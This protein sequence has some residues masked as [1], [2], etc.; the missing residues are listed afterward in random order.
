MTS[1][2]DFEKE[3][4]LEKL[5]AM[6]FSLDLCNLCLR[7]FDNDLKN[8]IQFLSENKNEWNDLEILLLKHIEAQNDSELE[9]ASTSGTCNKNAETAKKIF[10]GL[11][12][13]MTKDDEAYLDF[14]LDED[15]FFINKYYSL[16][17]T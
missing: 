1:N 11:A 10:A 9:E 3:D 7:A 13:E 8:A 12:E 6:G 17:R 4:D 14:N 2:P 15:S 16:L 5:I